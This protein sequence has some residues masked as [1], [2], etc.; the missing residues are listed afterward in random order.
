MLSDRLTE[1]GEA[2]LVERSVTDTR[3][4]GVSYGLTDSGRALV[5]IL[6]QLADWASSNLG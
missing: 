2:G 6:E 3:P 1:L 4:P 5:P